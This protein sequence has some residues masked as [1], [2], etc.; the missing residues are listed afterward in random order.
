MLAQSH[1][2][3][4]AILPFIENPRAL[5]RILAADA[6]W[7]LVLGIALCVAPWAG[8]PVLGI[9]IISWWPAFVIVG[10]GSLAFAFALLRAA[11]G[12]RIVETCTA[13][14]IA[15]GLSGGALILIVG[16]LGSLH[17][18]STML[19]LFVALVC[20]GFALLEWRQIR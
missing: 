15:N 2:Y 8:R 4:S 12:I 5:Q 17:D 16:L 7:D 1:G 20:G 11:Q 10:I 19:L 9:N 18:A 14:A 6:A 13:A 3:R